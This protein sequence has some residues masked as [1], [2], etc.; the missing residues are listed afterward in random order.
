[1][2]N[3]LHSSYNFL[4]QFSCNFERSDPKAKDILSCATQ[5]K[6]IIKNKR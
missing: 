3:T 6:E 2:M 1:M 5:S 4:I